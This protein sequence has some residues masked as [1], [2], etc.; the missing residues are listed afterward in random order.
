MN[1]IVSISLAVVSVLMLAQIALADQITLKN[2]DR[3]S[4]TIIKSDDK[5]LTIKS[6]LAG[7]ITVPMAAVVQITS[8]QPLHVALKDG[9]TVV[10]TVSGDTD[11]LEVK[12]ADSGT[13]SLARDSVVTVRSKD[14]QAAWERLQHPA[15]TELWGGALDAGL[16]L[17]QGNA[18]TSGFSFAMNAARATSRDKITLYTTALYA[19]NQTAGVTITTAN[20]KRG[21]ARYD[22]NLNS[23]S[24]GFGLGDLEA[25]DFQKLDLR[26]TLGGGLGWH[27]VKAERATLE[28]FGGGSMNKEYFTAG[29]RRT[30][31]EVLAGHEF[32]YRLN[33]RTSLKERTVIFPNLSETG[34]YRLIFDGSLAANIS[35]WL[36]WHLTLSDRYLSNPVF[37]TKSND[38]MLTTGIRLSFSR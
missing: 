11:K 32:T 7:T 24:F 35:K 16:S 18:K 9:K 22:I 15:L 14:E 38:V 12:T 26:L 17:T 6:E 5:S 21:G 36:G 20:A 2:G 30:S 33:G 34:E 29:L 4:G 31:G 3:I 19:R 37:G 28:I 1:R 13:V 8:D 25:D 27:A 23:R 10:G